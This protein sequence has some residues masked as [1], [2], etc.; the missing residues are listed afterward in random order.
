MNDYSRSNAFAVD[1]DGK[2]YV[3][4]DANGVDLSKSVG[5]NVEGTEYIIDGQTVVA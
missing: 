3:N 1:W 4:G 5:K 2:I